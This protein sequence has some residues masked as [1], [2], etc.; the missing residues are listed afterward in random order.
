VAA[1]S[2]CTRSGSGY[3]AIGASICANSSCL[4]T[5]AVVF[6]LWAKTP[7]GSV[8]EKINIQIIVRMKVFFIVYLTFTSSYHTI[9]KMN[10][11]PLDCYFIE[12]IGLL[13]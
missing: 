4:N 7:A 11:N 10:A 6:E 2:I 13:L 8:I 3:R 1:I 12:S 5:G 9:S